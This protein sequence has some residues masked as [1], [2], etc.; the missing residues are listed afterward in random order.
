MNYQERVSTRADVRALYE[1][2]LADPAIARYRGYTATK[3]YGWNEATQDCWKRDG[4]VWFENPAYDPSCEA[5]P[6]EMELLDE[7]LEESGRR[8]AALSDEKAE[9]CRLIDALNARIEVCEQNLARVEGERDEAL[10]ALAALR[11]ALQAIRKL[12][13]DALA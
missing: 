4:E 10:R 5:K 3:S 2:V 8:I 6:Q 9:L 7:R 12:T 13:E 11:E 1:K